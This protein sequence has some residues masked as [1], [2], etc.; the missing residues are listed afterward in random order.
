MPLLGPRSLVMSHDHTWDGAW[1]T[2]SGLTFAGCVACLRLSR[3]CPADRAIRYMVDIEHRCRP[4][5]SS[6]AHIWPIDR[7][8]YSPVLIN[9]STAVRSVAV[10]VVTGPGPAD[11]RARGLG[12]QLR[13]AEVGERRGQRVVGGGGVSVLSEMVSKSP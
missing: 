13:T 12:G 7:S 4:S 11:Q 8:A 5:S 9:V 10:P 6:R 3:V 1:A 2:S